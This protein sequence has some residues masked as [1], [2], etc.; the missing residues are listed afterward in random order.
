MVNKQ[1]FGK[2]IIIAK[3]K[4][5]NAV[6]RLN[7]SESPKI[8]YTHQAGSKVAG[9]ITEH[10]KISAVAKAKELKETDIA[11]LYLKT[12][13]KCQFIQTLRFFFWSWGCFFNFWKKLDF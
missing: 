5:T 4:K 1:R 9:T 7:G 3:F 6:G 10:P 13:L 8:I 2:R 12:L 11:T